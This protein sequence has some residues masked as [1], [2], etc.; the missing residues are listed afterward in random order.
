MAE[1]IFNK[2]APEGF[3]ATSSGTKVFDKDGNSK[4][5][6]KLKDRVGAEQVIEVLKELGI[7]AEEAERNQIT[8]ESVMA[9]DKIIIMAEKE[10]WPNYLIGSDKIIYW[11]II[12]PKA[13]SIDD[14]RAIRE[15]I[16]GLVERLIEDL[17]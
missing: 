1:A 5:G 13:K 9:A 10:T 8:E 17:K 3:S 11:D 12:D 14:T 16:H 7:R 4:E 6:E 2:L 15:Q